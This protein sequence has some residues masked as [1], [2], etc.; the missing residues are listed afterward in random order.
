[1]VKGH[2]EGKRRM[3]RIVC[4]FEQD[5][6]NHII[7]KAEFEGADTGVE[8]PFEAEAEEAIAESINKAILKILKNNL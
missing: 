4:G 3:R 5:T 2:I 7:K 6:F 1:M 8:S